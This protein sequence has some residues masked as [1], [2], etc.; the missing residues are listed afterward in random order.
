MSCPCVSIVSLRLDENST[1]VFIMSFI[2]SPS[3]FI[4]S[5]LGLAFLVALALVIFYVTRHRPYMVKPHDPESGADYMGMAAGEQDPPQF[6][7]IQQHHPP[8]YCVDDLQYPP[9]TYEAVFTRTTV[10]T[11]H[12]MH[13]LRKRLEKLKRRQ[14]REAAN[15]TDTGIRQ[16]NAT[17]SCETAIRDSEIRC[18]QQWIERLDT[19]RDD[20]EADEGMM[21]RRTSSFHHPHRSTVRLVHSQSEPA[22]L[23]TR[24]VTI[25]RET[26]WINCGIPREVAPPYS[27][28][29]PSPTLAETMDTRFAELREQMMRGLG[30]RHSTNR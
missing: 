28:P 29:P 27:V 10:P 14:R 5:L 1:A 24:I 3:V 8:V 18:L 20:E 13:L 15:S 11:Q 4:A 12:E 17:R 22:V 23:P 9:P 2:H 6:S 19:L 25:Q 26:G 21:T 16:S 30:G 7:E